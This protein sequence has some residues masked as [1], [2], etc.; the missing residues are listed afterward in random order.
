MD[1][2]IPRRFRRI[3]RAAMA[4]STPSLNSCA[5]VGKKLKTASTPLAIDIAIVSM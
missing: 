4:I 2:R 1:S 5:P 3:S